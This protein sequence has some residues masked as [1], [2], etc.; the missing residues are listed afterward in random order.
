MSRMIVA[1][2]TWAAI[3][4]T[5]YLFLPFENPLL[6]LGISVVL[7]GITIPSFTVF[8]P[9][10][11]GAIGLNIFTGTLYAFKP[12]AHFKYPWERVLEENYFKLKLVTQE[13]EETYAASDGPMMHV[14]AS[15]QYAP[16]LDGLNV[17]ITVDEK[18]IKEGFTDVVSSILSELISV[19]KAEDARTNVKKIE[20][21]VVRRIDNDAAVV[22]G[23]VKT[24]K[25]KLELQYGVNFRIFSIADIDFSPDFQEA[26]SGVARAEKLGKAA[27]AIQGGDASVSR[28]AALNFVLVE[29]KKAQKN[30]FEFEGSQEGGILAAVA[31]KFLSGQGGGEKKASK[32]GFQIPDKKGEE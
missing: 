25:D 20:N 19:E 13:F 15:Y 4:V 3:A 12:G 30:I 27:E 14:K 26:R 24:L 29:Q 17:Y 18:T 6:F 22:N 23:E 9:E 8:V 11:T 1:L 10:V 5:V 21:E 32:M 2:A 28:K 31:G 7:V 16:R